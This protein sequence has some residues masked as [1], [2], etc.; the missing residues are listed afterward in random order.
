MAKGRIKAYKDHV[1]RKEE[2]DHPYQIIDAH[3][4]AYL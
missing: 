2:A 4:F 3:L 1:R